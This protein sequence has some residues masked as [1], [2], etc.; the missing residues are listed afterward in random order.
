MV[1]FL[2][3]ISYENIGNIVAYN[4]VTVKIFITLGLL[5]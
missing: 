2:S 3:V 4:K 5:V 1:S